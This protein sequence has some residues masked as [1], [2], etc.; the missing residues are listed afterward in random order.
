MDEIISQI[1]NRINSETGWSNNQKIRYAYIELGKNIHKNFEFFYSC[2]D[3]M[4]EKNYTPEQ[5]MQIYNNEE[6]T[7]FTICKDCVRMLKYIFDNCNIETQVMSYCK[8]YNYLVNGENVSIYHTFLCVNGDNDKKYFLT[9]NSDLANIQMHFQTEHFANNIDY[10]DE[11]GNQIYNGPKIEHSIMTFKE[12]R[13]LD[14]SLGYMQCVNEDN[15]IINLDYTN[16]IFD[17]IFK[18]NQKYNNYLDRIVYS[19]NNVFY[20]KMLELLKSQD[21]DLLITDFKNINVVDVFKLEYFTC[22]LIKE[23]MHDDYNVIYNETDEQKLD[24]ML[25]SFDAENYLIY[26]YN[27]IPNNSLSNDIYNPKALLAN[28]ISFFRILEDITLNQKYNQ[29]LYNKLNKLISKISYCFTDKCYRPNFN[30]EQSN[31]YILKKIELVLSDLLDCGFNTVFSEMELGEKISILDKLFEKTFPELKL[32][33]DASKIDT[34]QNNRINRYIF[35]DKEAN[36]YKYLIEIDSHNDENA[37][38]LVYNLSNG[39]NYIE[40][41]DGDVSLFELLSND[42]NIFYSNRVYKDNKLPIK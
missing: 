35:F 30:G 37:I 25:N 27:K 3:V 17:A 4:H 11:D 9:L 21:K 42:K 14:N 19:E 28:C 40:G 1:I 15:E 31:D 23:K 22:N 6:F 36:E 10:F 5:L 29:N 8:P 39:K 18:Q 41:Y 26:L 7:N 34:K 13:E 2:F 12:L 20:F 16:S 33:K 38:N 24:E 32:C